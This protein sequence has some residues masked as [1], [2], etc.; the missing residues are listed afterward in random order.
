VG[1]KLADAPIFYTVGQIRFN[2][3]LNM[4]EYVAKLHE[5]LRK[6]F[7]DV[8]REETLRLQVNLAAA[9]NRDAVNSSASPRWKFTN[10]KKTTGYILHTDALVFH[11]TAYETSEEFSKALLRG[12]ELIDK[13][14]GLSYIEGVGLRTLDAVIPKQNK[15][16]D[17]YLH[18][19][20]LGFHGLLEGNLKHNITENVSFFPTGQQVSRVVILNG[21]IGIPVDLF[22]I[23]LTLNPK[24]QQLNALHAI[25]DLDHNRQERFE[26]DLEEVRARINQVKQGV[27]EV[28]RKIVTEQALETWA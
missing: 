4:G 11:T 21:S 25:L 19:Q 27:T 18:H 10:L 16:L 20:V 1:K 14:I 7:P 28:F 24:F 5:P 26:F 13:T 17:F 2:P 3:V 8:S 22:P 6:E 15:T 9:D 23:T 12:L